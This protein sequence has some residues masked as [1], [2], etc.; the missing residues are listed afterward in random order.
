MKSLKALALDLWFGF[1]LASPLIYSGIEGY[2]FVTYSIISSRT[3][4]SLKNS[5]SLPLVGRYIAI[6][7]EG[8]MLG[9][10]RRSG[11]REEVVD[12]RIETKGS[13]D[14]CQMARVPPQ[15]FFLS[16]GRSGKNLSSLFKKN[17]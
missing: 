3:A 17:L 11:R 1:T 7:I 15:A 10:W 14:L 4:R 12:G 8:E 2:S 13:I 16:S 9:I 6:C 5:I